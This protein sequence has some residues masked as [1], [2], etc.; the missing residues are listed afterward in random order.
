M[1]LKGIKRKITLFC[2][3][4]LFQGTRPYFWGIKRIILNWAGIKVGT[5]TKIVGPIR[6]F[7]DLDIGENIWIGTGLTVHGN[8]TLQIGDNCDIAP[9]V[10]F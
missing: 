10:T 2:D 1:T 6:V 8:G 3:N 5:G 9:D 4:K 7:G